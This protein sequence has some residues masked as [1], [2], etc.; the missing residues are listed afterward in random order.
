MTLPELVD[1]QNISAAAAVLTVLVA[2]I[3]AWIALAQ[4]AANRSQARE[5]IAMDT[6]RQLL[7]LC[8]ERP[9]LSSSTLMLKTLR[10]KTFAG[11][12]DEATMTPKTERALWFASYL[13]N[14][15]EQILES[16]P[17]DVAWRKT[18]TAQAGYHRALLEEVWPG[19]AEHYGPGLRTFM[20]DDVG[21]PS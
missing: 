7:C 21:L 14:T 13:L 3:A 15:I 1:A 5:A 10:R 19:W 17:K 18:M 8:I 16:N 20:R 9:E 2:G 12:E 4:I 6:H 11:I